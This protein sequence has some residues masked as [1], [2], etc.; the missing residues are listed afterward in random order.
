MRALLDSGN[1]GRQVPLPRGL[2]A[3]VAGRELR[4]EPGC[5]RS[6]DYEYSLRV[7]GEVLI[8]ELGCVITVE[9]AKTAGEQASNSGYNDAQLLNS[10]LLLPELKVRNW[11]AGDR[12]WPAHRKSPKKLKEL[13]L[14]KRVLHAEKAVWPVLLSG[15]EIVWVR[16]LPVAER[17]GAKAEDV[18]ALVVWERPCR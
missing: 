11:R 6:T 4:I 8:P 7:P 5:L 10:R 9:P 17:F 12:F 2:L 1:T 16:G 13:L 18:M 14:E 3:Q 15:D